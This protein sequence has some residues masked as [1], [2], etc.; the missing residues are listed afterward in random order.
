MIA[1]Y[2]LVSGGVFA[3][4][5]R[6]SPLKLFEFVEEYELDLDNIENVFSLDKDWEQLH[7]FLTAEKSG[8]GNL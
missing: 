6:L 4:L 2:M 8:E 5:K 7:G 1:N 3:E